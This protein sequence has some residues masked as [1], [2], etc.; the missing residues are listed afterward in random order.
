MYKTN[1][2]NRPYIKNKKTPL[3]NKKDNGAEGLLD[4]LKS[5][6][7]MN[8][9]ITKNNQKILVNEYFIQK[10]TD[11]YMEY[12]KQMEALNENQELNRENEFY[13]D[14]LG[15]LR[16]VE[17]LPIDEYLLVINYLFDNQ[18][19]TEDLIDEANLT[20][21]QGLS[22]R[23]KNLIKKAYKEHFREILTEN[24]AS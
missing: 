6:R 22:K 24:E 11:D 13:Q 19:D 16:F 15:T 4:L 5:A 18:K 20:T 1:T 17:K 9:E 14:M 8:H 3:K 12:N 7:F 21:R 2:V 23:V 10:E